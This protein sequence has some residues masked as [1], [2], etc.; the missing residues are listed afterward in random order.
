[1]RLNMFKKGMEAVFIGAVSFGIMG[2]GMSTLANAQE[3]PQRQQRRQDIPRRQGQEQQTVQPQ[4][5]LRRARAVQESTQKTAP[6]AQP[7]ETL[8]IRQRPQRNQQPDV[9]RQRQPEREQQSQQQ[10]LQ[11][12][13]QSQQ[14]LQRQQRQQV[15]QQRM[16]QQELLRRQQQQQGMRQQQQEQLRI[17]QQQEL[18]RRQQQQRSQ[19]SQQ[20]LPQQRQQQ[21]IR[22]QQHRIEQYRGHLDQQNRLAQQR[23]YLLQQQRRQA[24]YRFQQRYV[25]RLRQQQQSLGNARNYD[26]NRDPYFYTAPNYRYSR[27]GQYYQ[28]NQ[29]AADQLRQSVNFGYEEGFRAGQ[30]DQQDGWRYSYQDSYPYQDANYGYT[31]YY[32]DRAEYNHYFREGFLRGYEDGYHSRN[33]Y[34]VHSNGSYS[35]L[36]AIL[37][38]ILNLQSFGD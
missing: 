2:G 22:E 32:V 23:S 17:Q 38:Q 31:G 18:M 24:Q 1:M 4:Q 19:V 5:E 16:Q 6:A 30:A 7:A 33:R 10:Q 25:E 12:E 35:I 11:R 9:F 8:I 29:Y 3:P 26:Y 37:G 15:E 20:R 34:G 28:V 36:G 21:L 14:Q 27:G 13:Q